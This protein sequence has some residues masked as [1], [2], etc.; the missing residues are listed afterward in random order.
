MDPI[1]EI[2]AMRNAEAI[3]ELHDT[4]MVKR[5]WAYMYPEVHLEVLRAL[6]ARAKRPHD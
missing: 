3:L 2:S 6:L 4:K 5:G 1:D